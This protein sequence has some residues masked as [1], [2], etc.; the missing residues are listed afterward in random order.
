MTMKLLAAFLCLLLLTGCGKTEAPVP[1]PTALPEQTLHVSG[2]TLEQQNSGI[3]EVFSTGLGETCSLFSIG[4]ALVLSGGGHTSLYT[5]SSLRLT[6]QIPEENLI[7]GDAGTLWFYDQ[8]TRQISQLDDTL[9]VVST[10]SLPGG[11]IGTPAVSEDAFYF[12]RQDGLYALERTTGLTRLL[13]DNMAVQDGTLHCLTDGQTLLV[14][15][16]DPNGEENTQLISTVDGSALYEDLS[17]QAAAAFP[18][19]L[20]VGAKPGV[21]QKIL[22]LSDAPQRLHTQAQEELVEFLP[23]ISGAVTKRDTAE[24]TELKLYLLTTGQCR[25]TLTLSGIDRV[26]DPIVT[27]SGQVYLLAHDQAEDQWLILRWHYDAFPL[28]NSESCLLPYAASATE[29]EKNSSLE[30]AAALHQKYGLDIRIYEDAVSVKPWDYTFSPMEAA[31]ETDWMLE[32]LDTLLRLFPE[33]FLSRLQRGWEGLSLCLVDTIR[34]TSASGS[35]A[36]AA[37]LQSQED[38]EYYVTLSA[39]QMEDLRY[40]LFHEF[41]HLIDSQVLENCS[42]YDNWQDLNPQGF[43]YSLDASTDMGK[44]SAYLSGTSRCFVDD[45]AMVS[46]S[47]DRARIFECAANPGNEDLFTPPLMQAKLRRICEGIRKAFDLED[48]PTQYIWEQ[49]LIRYASA[50]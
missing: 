47:E 10:D 37:G 49:Y 45:Y 50:P 48:D 25:S 23:G 4:D 6:A 33:G 1:E 40:T 31:D 20:A 14:H 38:G 22:L 9:S 30:K 32:N 28:Q 5:G 16:V 27:E 18:E 7:S 42:A 19:G 12:L 41:S 15:L 3:V 43:S 26:R 35:L 21:F 11:A 36:T 24:G 29:Q 34:G 8:A 17:P 39:A 13:R 44:Y 46:P 2:H